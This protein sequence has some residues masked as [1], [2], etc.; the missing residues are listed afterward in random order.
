[1]TNA[2]THR[3]VAAAT[4][5]LTLTLAA[6]GSGDTP[7]AGT[8]L[9]SGLAPDQTILCASN[10]GSG[11]DTV[12]IQ[13][14]GFLSEHGADIEVLWTA[15]TGTPFSGGTSATA[16][17]AGTVL[18][19]NQVEVGVPPGVGTFDVTITVTLPGGNSGTSEPQELSIGGFLVGPF[20]QPDTLE[21]TI[22]NV[23]TTVAAPGV[24]EN[25]IGVT[26]AEGEGEP[27]FDKPSVGASTQA[28]SFAVVAAPNATDASPGL[29]RPTA[30]GGTVLIQTDGGFV[31]TPP[32]GVTNQSDSFTYWMTDAGE[33]P[34]PAT[35]TLPITNM[36]WFLDR[37]DDG[38]NTGHFDDPFQ[39]IGDFM[40]VQGGGVGNMQ[41]DVGHT[42]FIHDQGG[43]PPYDGLLG[44]IDDQTLLGEGYG[45]EIDGRVIVAP[46]SRPVLVNSQ[47]A[48]GE[49]EGDTVIG[50][51]NRNTIRGLEIEAPN[52]FGIQGFF[53]SGPTLIDDV[54][55]QGSLQDGIRLDSVSG[56]FQVGD[57]SNANVPTVRIA[58]CGSDGIQIDGGQANFL[59]A[60]LQQVGGP[61]LNVYSADISGCTNGRGIFATDANVDCNLIMIDDCQDGILLQTFAGTCTISVLNSNIGINQIISS[62]GI[63]LDPVNSFAGIDAYIGFTDIVGFELALDG[64]SAGGGN[65]EIALERN[66]FTNVVTGPLPAVRLDG[67]VQSESTV[68]TQMD[69]IIVNGNNT[70]GGIVCSGCLFDADPDTAGSQTVSTASLQIG[71]GP[72]ARVEFTALQLLDCNGD[73]SIGTLTIWQDGPVAAGYT[74][75]GMLVLTITTEVID[76]SNP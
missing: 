64:G 63:V 4:L 28:N 51:G 17:T 56:T 5:L 33:G 15:V 20:P 41:P 35:V 25:D 31:Y 36:V 49:S 66:N 52:L 23:P 46:G 9:V 61:T 43:S 10:N 69:Q 21:G 32:V 3:T 45:L 13:G 6:C 74:N 75:T 42:I 12:L 67:D 26:C 68:I 50:L 40:A 11:G 57:P 27:E 8:V 14:S 18:S 55:I 39:S 76:V 58:N 54:G 34:A 48:I 73:F 72:A 38:A 44:L 29:V 71:N 19:D 59:Q 37:N 62:R 1:M 24:L 53:V 65:L 7:G 16:M 22:G 70:G 60:G 30:L 47:F 2:K